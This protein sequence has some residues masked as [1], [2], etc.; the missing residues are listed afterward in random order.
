MIG[1]HISPDLFIVLAT[2]SFIIGYL[3]IN[4]MLLRMAML[5]GSSFFIACYATVAAEPLW[6]AILSS[7]LMILANLTGLAGLY[8]RRAPWSIPKRHRDIARHFP[9]LPPGDIRTLLHH[10]DRQVLRA[11]RVVTREGIRP[12]SVVFVLNGHMEVHKQGRHFF[13]PP[14]LF[15]GEVAYLLRQP[16]AAT[17][18][19]PLG[20]EFLEWPMERLDRICRRSPR[21]KLAME[22]AMSRDLASKVAGAVAMSEWDA[23]TAK[24]A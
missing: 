21:F 10:A 3:I 1:T 4:Q 5:M 7:F 9:H 14:G 19:L 15:A 20:T 22:A 13:L 12:R 17:T 11:P 23:Q 6:G 24:P 16:S 8:A 2:G 18:T